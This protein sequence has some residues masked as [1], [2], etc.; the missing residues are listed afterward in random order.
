MKIRQNQILVAFLSTLLLQLPA[1]ALTIFGAEIDD[2]IA[3]KYIDAAC[4]TEITTDRLFDNM[5]DDLPWA[6]IK[7]QILQTMP[8]F[9]KLSNGDLKEKFRIGLMAAATPKKATP[10]PREEQKA[11][12]AESAPLE[13]KAGADG[14]VVGLGLVLLLSALIKSST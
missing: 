5:A 7:R 2:K 13:Q 8:E 14:L 4:S 11:P 12:T 3:E 9:R 10:A 6:P 1:F